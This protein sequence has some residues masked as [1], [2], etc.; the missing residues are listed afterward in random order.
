MGYPRPL[1]ERRHGVRER[2]EQEERGQDAKVEPAEVQ[3]QAPEEVEERV[4]DDEERLQQR[5][6]LCLREPGQQDARGNQR[7]VQC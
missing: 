5:L 3:S 7:V 2:V 4:R 1:G 6:P